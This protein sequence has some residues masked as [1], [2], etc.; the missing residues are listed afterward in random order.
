MKKIAIN[1]YGRIG[2]AFL[3]AYYKRYEQLHQEFEIVKI[4]QPSDPSAI[5]YLTE[6]DSL[7]GR[8]NHL[9]ELELDKDS[10]KSSLLIDKKS[11]NLNGA[12]EPEQLDWSDI[13]ILLES[14]GSFSDLTTANKHLERGASK[15]LFAQPATNAAEATI[16]C[17]FNQQTLQKDMRIISA[18]SCTT[19]CLIP[20]LDILQNTYAIESVSA[21]TLHSYMADQR[22][23]DSFAST[24]EET[25]M[26]SA[27][28]IVPIKTQ[29]AVGVE[30]LMPNL[31]GRIIANH[32]RLPSLGASAMEIC[33][34]LE[35]MPS[36]LDEV[37]QLFVEKANGAYAEILATTTKNL[38]SIDYLGDPHSTNIDLNSISIVKNKLRLLAWFDS[39]WAF[40]NRLLDIALKI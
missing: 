33:L 16:I 24:S 28:S 2:R 6:F 19:N 9:V 12:Y 31:E 20:I 21:T 14:T 10:A 15:I 36:N 4:N 17:G 18:A 25:K 22:F 13:D 23:I 26:R 39:E 30:R 8:F 38:V 1:G 3:R 32:I 40:A 27:Q 34:D 7:Y 5:A 11:I 37:K 29:L 35:K